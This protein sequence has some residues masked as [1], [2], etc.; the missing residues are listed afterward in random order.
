MKS[1]LCWCGSNEKY[2]S[3]HYIFDKRLEA[4]KKEGYL[5]PKKSMIKNADQIKGIKEAA[6]I[7]NL[8]LDHI[9]ENIKAGITTDDIDKMAQDF[10]KSKNAHSADLG[11]E[12]YPK[13][14]CTSVNDCICHG[15][16]SKNQV[17]KDGDII[18]VDATTEYNGFYADASRMF[19][20]G[21]VKENAKRLVEVTKKCLDEATKMIVPWETTTDEIG[22][23]IEKIAKENGYSV[24][25]EYTGHGV[26]L[27]MHENPYIFHFDIKEEG[28]LIVPGMVFT[29]EPMINEGRKGIRFKQGDSWSSFT[30]DG[31]LSA[32][33]EY[34]IIVNEDN[35]E[36][37]S[38]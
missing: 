19:M 9:E 11:Y 6:V 35:V 13:S 37:V 36:I 28:Y 3:C 26:G 18:N 38:F 5:I 23:L 34:T 4:Y 7:N 33:W 14:I 15:I 10:L 29:I 12:G 2:R 30:V 21:E 1:N 17:L 24:V 22:K 8:L 25:E 27:K 16:P 32:Q 31:K 20:I